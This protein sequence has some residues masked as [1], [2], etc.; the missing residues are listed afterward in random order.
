MA[1]AKTQQEIT[2][3]AKLITRHALWILFLTV[4]FL[5]VLT[6]RELTWMT[7]GFGALKGLLAAILAWIF[8]L[9][10]FDA[11]LRSIKASAI[12]AQAKRRDGGLLYHFLPPDPDEVPEDFPRPA[13][14][15]KPAKAG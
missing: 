9:I 12:E 4:F 10:V 3:M 15:E 2:A 14:K 6:S 5:S 1:K 7:L 13:A 8:F 11:I